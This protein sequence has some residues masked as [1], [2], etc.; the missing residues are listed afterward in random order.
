[1]FSQKRLDNFTA[2]NLISVSD[3]VGHPQ[4]NKKILLVGCRSYPS[5][6]GQYIAALISK[7][8]EIYYV[9][10]ESGKRIQIQLKET[11]QGKKNSQIDLDCDLMRFLPNTS[12]L[13][14]DSQETNSEINKAL[15]GETSS[16]WYIMDMYDFYCLC[17]FEDSRR[18][19]TLTQLPDEKSLDGNIQYRYKVDLGEAYENSIETK[20][21]KYARIYSNEFPLAAID[22]LDLAGSLSEYLEIYFFGIFK[23]EG[24][25]FRHPCCEKLRVLNLHSLQDPEICEFSSFP[26]SIEILRITNC[27]LG[28]NLDKGFFDPYLRLSNLT[29]ELDSVSVFEP[30]KVPGDTFVSFGDFCVDAADA[31]EKPTYLWQPTKLPSLPPSLQKLALRGLDKLTKLPDLPAGLEELT[32]IGLEELISLP[33]LPDTLKSLTIQGCTN[34]HDLR[35]LTE[36]SKLDKL[37]LRFSRSQ[38]ESLKSPTDLQSAEGSKL[39]FAQPEQSPKDKTPSTKSTAGVP[40]APTQEPTTAVPTSNLNSSGSPALFNHCISEPIKKRAK[41]EH[42][43]GP[44]SRQA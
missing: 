29:I 44:G 11:K 37:D 23:D 21:K 30:V 3:G 39:T 33:K 18:P 17:A 32:L 5:A 28:N 2:T 22:V 27:C 16:D 31:P 12:R 15:S 38:V 6:I 8:F 19:V 42:F 40:P 14:N 9:N 26:V 20:S 4:K 41:T 10:E 24:E 34:L 43:K 1:M 25:L 36:F 7:G 35:A 13:S